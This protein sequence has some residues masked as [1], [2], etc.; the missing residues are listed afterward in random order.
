MIIFDMEAVPRDD[1][2]EQL[3]LFR[4]SDLEL[5]KQDSRLKDP[6]KK[7]EN[8]KKVQEQNE[9]LITTF[10]DNDGKD[11]DYAKIIA[12]GFIK[13]NEVPK[14]VVVNGQTTELILLEKF[15]QFLAEEKGPI[16][17]YNIGGYDIP[18]LKRRCMR[19]G[20][21]FPPVMRQKPVDI[22]WELSEWKKVKPKKLIELAMSQGFNANMDVAKASEIYPKYIEGDLEYIK[23]HLAQDLLMTELIY[24][25]MKISGIIDKPFEGSLDGYNPAK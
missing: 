2:T 3:I 16:V 21:L 19:Y 18:L 4:Q 14:T 13:N 5:K 17:G 22:M 23:E 8:I 25:E 1:L 7:A 6:V 11:V 9:L 10:R 20:I 15:N 12:I 24:D